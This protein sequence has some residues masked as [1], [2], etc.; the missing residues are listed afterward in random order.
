VWA[1]R[2]D[3]V[4]ALARGARAASSFLRGHYV[5]TRLLLAPLLEL[6][7]SLNSSF[8]FARCEDSL[9]FS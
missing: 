6:L 7:N 1:Y 3:G 9:K 5:D 4:W 8:A 2:R